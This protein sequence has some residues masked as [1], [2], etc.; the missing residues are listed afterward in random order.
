MDVALRVAPEVGLLDEDVEV[1]VEGAAPH[2]VVTLRARATD[3]AGRAWVSE[4]VFVADELGR[5]D[6]A[7]AA[8]LDGSF[9]CVDPM[10][11]FWSMVPEDGQAPS[12]FAKESAEPVVVAIEAHDD[13]G[14]AATVGVRRLLAGPGVTAVPLELPG[15]E[16]TLFRPAGDGPFPA[17]LVLGG[18][19]GL[20][21]EGAAALLASHGIAAA[22]VSYFGRPGLPAELAEI[23]LENL[24]AAIDHLVAESWVR[25]SIGVVGTSRGAEAAA[26][27]GIHCPA[28]GA[29]V[30]F[31]GSP[32]HHQAMTP[33]PARP[34]W[35]LG[36]EA[37][38]FL[39]LE[40]DFAAAMSAT[41]ERP[42]E[43]TATFLAALEREDEV[44]RATIPLERC[45]APMLFVAG[46]DDRVWPSAAFAERAAARMAEHG[47][48]DDV[49][50]LRYPDAG[51]HLTVPNLPSTGTVSTARAFRALG[52]TGKGNAHAN[53]DSWAQHV[54]FLTEAL[55]A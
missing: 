30:A 14:L 19:G 34:T 23:P 44:A 32:F 12:P 25:P 24:L 47:R 49:T 42:F 11:L 26:L 15:V 38:D 36:G 16:G 31:A 37:I 33:G 41:L 1:T 29:V 18:S 22:A 13:G 43:S 20:L 9:G 6:V 40:I 2:D 46:E 3:D 55:G 17:A 54:R 52:G 48:A 21:L 10:G 50:V 51:H 8:P 5:V 45:T 35:T 39:P 27:L 7:K 28:V 4:A 53:A